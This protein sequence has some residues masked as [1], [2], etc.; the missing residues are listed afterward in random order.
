MFVSPFLPMALDYRVSWT[1]PGSDLGVSIAVTRDGRPLLRA[2]M[3]LRRS[4]LDRRAAVRLL[5]RHPMAPLRGSVAI[6][7]KALKLWM[8]H[9]P[10]YRHSSKTATVLT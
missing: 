7:R 5:A 2:E 4:T 10:L 3:A 9:A 8:D 1:T 6:Y